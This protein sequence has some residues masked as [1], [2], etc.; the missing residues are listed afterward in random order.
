MEH[1]FFVKNGNLE[2]VNR[3]LSKGGRIKSIHALSES[4][5]AYGYAGGESYSDGKGK[6]VGD[7]YAYIVV[8]F[9]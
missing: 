4:V 9:D 7:V 1:V 6:C 2:E 3:F 8:E 5:S